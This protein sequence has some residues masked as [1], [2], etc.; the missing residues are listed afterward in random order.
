L[1][2]AGLLQQVIARLRNRTGDLAGTLEAAARSRE[3]FLQLMQYAS[4]EK[5]LALASDEVTRLGVL[6]GLAITSAVCAGTLLEMGRADEALAAHREFLRLE[7]QAQGVEPGSPAAAGMLVTAHAFQSDVAL[8]RGQVAEAQA[9][10]RAEIAGTD[11]AMRHDPSEV[12]M[13]RDLADAHRHLGQALCA[14]A[15]VK[16]CVAELA[17]A[18]AGIGAVAEKDPGLMLNRSMQAGTLNDYG[19]ALERAGRSMEAR[20]A[21]RSALALVED[22]VREAPNRAD[23]IRERARSHQGLKD[24]A[25]GADWAEFRRRSPLSRHI[26][27]ERGPAAY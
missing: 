20:A 9:E 27:G 17:A 22:C 21:F 12:S 16:A 14:A 3:L 11:E 7:Q 6:H 18:A 15:A 13:Q 4:A 23:L 19:A 2:A 26:S 10:A 24:A 1:N 8:F 25:A 5:P